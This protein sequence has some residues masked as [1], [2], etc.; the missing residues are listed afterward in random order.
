L[1]TAFSQEDFDIKAMTPK[2]DN[3]NMLQKMSQRIEQQ[4]VRQKT[5]S[6]K[7]SSKREADTESIWTKQAFEMA[8]QDK[9]D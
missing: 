5:L 6:T 7:H 2:V 8:E 3:I 4:H 1:N 9:Q